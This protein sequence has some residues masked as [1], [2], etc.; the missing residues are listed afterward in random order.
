MPGGGD[1]EGGLQ[2]GEDGRIRAGYALAGP[3]YGSAHGFVPDDDAVFR[4]EIVELAEGAE[5]V[6]FGQRLVEVGFGA[7]FGTARLAQPLDFGPGV[8]GCNE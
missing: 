1:L 3:G 8:E 2:I 4:L 7:D 5:Q 6:V